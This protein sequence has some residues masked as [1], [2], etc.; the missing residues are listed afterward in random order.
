MYIYVCVYIYRQYA[1]MRRNGS[2][3]CASMQARTCARACMQAGKQASSRS[4]E[5][6]S[7]HTVARVRAP[8]HSRMAFLS[9]CPLQ[10]FA[11]IGTLS[12]DRVDSATRKRTRTHMRAQ[13]G[14]AN[15]PT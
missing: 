11:S 7:K 10:Q 14:Q 2:A 4:G 15:K 5:R 6:A 12:R 1:R 13:N 9:F 3:A 8:L